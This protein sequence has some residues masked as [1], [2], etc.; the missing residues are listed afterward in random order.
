MNKR[1]RKKIARIK[2]SWYKGKVI[3]DY[4]CPCCS[5]SALVDEE[6]KYHRTLTTERSYLGQI[7]WEF[8]VKCPHCKTVFGYWDSNM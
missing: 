7:D 6:M 4:E 8:E 3:E 1:Q 5:W 2:N